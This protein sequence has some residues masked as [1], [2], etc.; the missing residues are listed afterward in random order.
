MAADRP[1][2]FN[3]QLLQLSTPAPVNLLLLQDKHQHMFVSPKQVHNIC[4]RDYCTYA[5]FYRQCSSLKHP[6]VLTEQ[7]PQLQQLIHLAGMSNTVSKVALISLTACCQA[8]A[9]AKLKVP[10]QLLAGFVQL[11]DQPPEQRVV[12]SQ[13]GSSP[14]QVQMLR[15]FPVSLPACQVPSSSFGHQYG[16]NTKQ[17]KHLLTKAPIAQQLTSLHSYCTTTIRLDRP[18]HYFK[19]RTWQNIYTQ[20]A[21]FL[22]YCLTYHHKSQPNM[23]FFLEPTLIIHFVSYH[24]AAKHSPGTIRG[25]LFA[26]KKVIQ[27]WA[28]TSGGQHDSFREGF[29]WLQA[30]YTQVLHHQHSSMPSGIS[31]SAATLST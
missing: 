8:M 25:F 16:L 17:K 26:A 7:D 10:S 3:F 9:K 12:I 15:P 29:A 28:S 1:P 4:L 18:G 23:D 30:L 27:W 11:K 21:L 2:K 22:G 31:I 19:D 14:A 5:A 6:M 20:C 13:H 24:I